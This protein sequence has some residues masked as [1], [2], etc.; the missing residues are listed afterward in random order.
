M[1][2][3]GKTISELHALYEKGLPKMSATP[4][5][6]V[7]QGGRIHIA[8]KKLLNAKGKGKRK[9]KRKDKSYTLSLK[10]LNLMLKSTRQ[11]MM[12]ATTSKRHR[13]TVSS[14]MDTAYWSSE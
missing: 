5:V 14:L 8:N 9:G 4:Q 3:M 1:H 13:Y 12:A 7:T 2:N 11:R 6:M 10:T